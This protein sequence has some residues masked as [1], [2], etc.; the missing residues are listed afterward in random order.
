MRTGRNRN[1]IGR[2]IHFTLQKAAFAEDLDEDAFKAT[3]V[4]DIFTSIVM[5]SLLALPPV[6]LLLKFTV[7]NP[8]WWQ[9]ALLI[10]LF[11]LVGWGVILTAYVGEQARIA[12]CV[13]WLAVYSLAAMI[14]RLFTS[15]MKVMT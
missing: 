12:Y 2:T 9:I 4:N 8:A 10:A 13:L 7:K 11:V 3:S 15:E 6:L 1:Q 5:C 14:R